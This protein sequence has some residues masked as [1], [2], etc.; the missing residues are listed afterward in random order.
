MNVNMWIKQCGWKEI[1]VTYM[2]L[3]ALSDCLEEES[4][5][6]TQITSSCVLVRLDERDIREETDENA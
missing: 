5:N 2:L 4:F 6:L 3:V 1:L